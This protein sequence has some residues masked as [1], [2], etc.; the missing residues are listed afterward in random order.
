ML[1]REQRRA[2]LKE[3]NKK[4]IIDV[5]KGTLELPVKGCDEPLVIDI[6]NYENYHDLYKLSR[7][8]SNPQ[9]AYSADF[10][11]MDAEQDM[12]VKSDMYADL[13]LKIVK[14]FASCVDSVFGKGATSK[15]FG[16]TAP[17]PPVMFEFIDECI[18]PILDEVKQYMDSESGAGVDT[19]AAADAA[20]AALSRVG[21]V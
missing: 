8:F 5:T 13:T 4:F 3:M 19:R 1:N 14:D 6:M 21:N 16:N 12:D 18:I 10:D 17:M 20:G 2:K 15:I 7:K 11:A 9:K